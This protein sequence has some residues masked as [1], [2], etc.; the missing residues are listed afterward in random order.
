MTKSFQ[1]HSVNAAHNDAICQIVIYDHNAT[2]YSKND[3]ISNLWQKFEFASELV[4]D[5]RDTVNLQ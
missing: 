1:A 4:S 3:W 5:L 2:L